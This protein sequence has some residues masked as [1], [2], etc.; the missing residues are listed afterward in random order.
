MF[1]FDYRLAK[2]FRKLK[3]IKLSKKKRFFYGNSMGDFGLEIELVE[4]VIEFPSTNMKLLAPNN[5][6]VNAE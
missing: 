6:L 4:F 3:C 2:S 5:N 1:A